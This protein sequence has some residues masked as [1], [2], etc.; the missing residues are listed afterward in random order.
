MR[1]VLFLSAIIMSSWALWA[2]AANASASDVSSM[3]EFDQQSC[4]LDPAEAGCIG[5]GRAT[6]PVVRV[7]VVHPVHRVRHHGR[8]MVHHS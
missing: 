2:P 1:K 3:Y 6:A 8:T 5:F 7:A 4:S